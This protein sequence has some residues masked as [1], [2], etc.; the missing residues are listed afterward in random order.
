MRTATLPAEHLPPLSRS[1]AACLAAILELETDEVPAP[2]AEHPEPWTAWR[3]WLAGR[4]L[5][6]V[7]VANPRSFDWPGPWIAL[8]QGDRAAVA[9]GSPAGGLAWAPLG[10]TFGDLEGGFA[11][12]PFDTGLWAQRPEASAREHGTVEAIAI[13]PAAEAPMALVG[14]AAA[15]AGRGLKGDRYFDGAGTFSNPH[16]NGHHLT[17]IEAEVVDALG[18]PPAEARR[19]VVTRGIDLNA[20]VGR[21]FRVGETEC[22]GRRLCEPCAQL[23]RLTHDGILRDLVHRGGLRADILS[24]GTIRTGDDVLALP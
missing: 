7:P 20:L 14:D 15:H 2:G 6:L 5:G 13:A 10:G 21:R 8:L 3:T 16:S 19:N 17:L 18:L 11:L 4:G 23:Q 12:A 24:G 1:V 9:Y 22:I